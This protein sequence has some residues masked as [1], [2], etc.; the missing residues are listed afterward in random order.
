MSGHVVESWTA[1]LRSFS[2]AM[3]MSAAFFRSAV[4][5]IWSSLACFLFEHDLFRKPVPTFRDH[6]RGGRMLL[7]SAGQGKPKWAQPNGRLALKC[8][9]RGCR[10]TTLPPKAGIRNV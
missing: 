7:H 4:E 2:A 1:C 3:R 10:V 6:A 8:A 5:S 9:P